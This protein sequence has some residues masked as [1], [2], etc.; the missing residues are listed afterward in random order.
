MVIS[1][2]PSVL[3]FSFLLCA[4]FTVDLLCSK[5]FLS[6][7]GNSDVS[8]LPSVIAFFA[9]SSASLLPLTPL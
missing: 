5:A 3:H 7:F 4:H 8:L 1:A 2:M 6:A 9:C